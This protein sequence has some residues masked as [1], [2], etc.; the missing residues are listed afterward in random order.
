M[1]SG[2]SEA[3]HIH[4]KYFV[5][6][7]N[8][9][10]SFFASYFDDI[11]VT[12]NISEWLEGVLFEN[13]VYFIFVRLCVHVSTLTKKFLLS[14][15]IR[16]RWSK[17]KVEDFYGGERGQNFGWR[18]KFISFSLWLLFW[19]F[20]NLLWKPKKNMLFISTSVIT[21]SRIIA[22]VMKCFHVQWWVV[23]ITRKNYCNFYM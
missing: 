17:I 3:R 12:L 1:A 13:W 6:S 15:Q 22:E 14:Y 21:F 5:D 2:S 19:S 10:R 18:E 9:C 8:Y 23:I 11:T 16:L 20:T 7:Q 4:S